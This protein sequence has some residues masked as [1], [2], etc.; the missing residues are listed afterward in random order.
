MTRINTNVSSLAAQHR[1]GASNSALQ[2]ALTR[3]SS[4]FRI[5]SGKD[6][7]AGLI[8]SEVLRSEISAI[9]QSI[10]N[11]ERASNVIS[12]ADAALGEVSKLL[13]DVRT[14]IQSSANKGAV[15]SSEI[16]ANQVELDSALSTI[17]RVA[18]TTL[19]AGDK[20]LDGSKAFSVNATG[21]SLGAFASPS[22]LRVTS[23]NP[24]LHSSTAGDDV[25][26][27]V[28]TAALQEVVTLADA[29]IDNLDDGVAGNTTTIEVIGDL[30]RAVVVLDND[31][32]VAA[33]SYVR[34]QINSVSAT[35][36][37]T[38]ALNGANVELTS[39]NY[40]TGAVVTASAIASD[41]AADITLFNGALQSITQAG[42]D[43]AGT[44]THSLGGGAFTG[45]GA[46]ITYTDSS[47]TLAGTTDPT[48][49]TATAN[50]DVTGGAIFQIGPQVNFANQVSI[51][52]ISL[53][54]AT[55]GRDVNTTGNKGL[56]SLQT[57]GNDVLTSADLS[58]AASLVEQAIDQIATLRGQLG[59]I[60]KNVLESNVNSLQA[61]LE[62]VTA[63]ESSIR[64][65]DFAVETANL[66]RAQILQQTG[67]SVLSIA[68]SSPQ[69]VLALLG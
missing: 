58:D 32:A 18:Q 50:V 36:G 25:T 27:A 67:I 62:Q 9:G 42:V 48:L 6:D 2:T 39:A 41:V 44:V 22:D 54:L 12:T 5:N 24:A 13:N 52:L 16:A 53:D 4:G 49:G 21:G 40:G 1:L 28:T 38:A 14:L 31:S 7:P 59:S 63:A 61:T 8:A 43:V 15:S 46:E 57:G 3:L 66:T 10:K 47:L 17:A 20:L 33:S 37:V 68:N 29:Q 34:D 19:F 45:N 26:L 69:A 35:T 55:L 30:G 65:A 56:S 11:T 51:S 64:D 23:F 60:Q